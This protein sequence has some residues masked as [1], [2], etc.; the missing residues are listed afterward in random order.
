[1]INIMNYLTARAWIWDVD[2]NPDNLYALLISGAN[3][4]NAAL[5]HLQTARETDPEGY[6]QHHLENALRAQYDSLRGDITHINQTITNGNTTNSPLPVAG[7]ELVALVKSIAE[8][9]KKGEIETI[10]RS[11]RDPRAT[12][13]AVTQL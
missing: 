6:N 13:D 10:M 9:L 12:L 4:Y 3:A 2:E 5:T 11:P 8:G 7:P 1:M